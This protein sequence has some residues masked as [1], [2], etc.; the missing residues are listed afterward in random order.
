M[1]DVVIDLRDGGDWSL[2]LCYAGLVKNGLN[3]IDIP[4]KKKHREWFDVQ[5]GKITSDWGLERRTLGFC[6]NK[7][8]FEQSEIDKIIKFNQVKRVWL[9]ERLESFIKWKSLGLHLTNAEV[10]VVAGHDRF[11]NHSPEFVA[12]LYGK[13]FKAMLLDNWYDRY[14][15]LQ[16]PVMRIGWSTNFDHYWSRPMENVD[17]QFD[18]CFIG[19]NSHPDREYYINHI[20]EKWGFLNNYIILEK[21]NNSFSNFVSKDKMFNIMLRSKI[22]LNLR[23]AAD[24]GK[25]L[26]S[27]EIPYVGSF[28][29]SQRIEDPGLENDFKNFEEAVYFNNTKELDESIDCFIEYDFIDK[30]IPNLKNEKRELIALN[31]LHKANNELSVKN[32][33]K[34]VLEWLNYGC[35]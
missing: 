28:M 22:C 23:G 2:D 11:W 33:W 9:D 20:Q 35:I 27:Y 24:K 1:Y 16:F 19:F 5:S 15:K 21:E 26:R 3:V 25:T 8:T 31:G 6:E 29:L 10:I 34:N 14:S 32:R 4:F 7:L 17:K 12:N 18:I 30:L 13:N